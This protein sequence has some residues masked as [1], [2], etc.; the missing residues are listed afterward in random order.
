MFAEIRILDT[1]WET[2]IIDSL[3]ND[4]KTPFINSTSGWA[5][6]F[7]RPNQICYAERF[8][9]ESSTKGAVGYIGESSP[10]AHVYQFHNVY[11]DS[12]NYNEQYFYNLFVKNVSVAA[13]LMLYSKNKCFN[14]EQGKKSIKYVYNLLGDPALNI[15]AS[16]YKITKPTTVPCESVITTKITVSGRGSLIVPDS[17]TLTFY[18]DGDLTVDSG[19]YVVIGDGA[20]INADESAINS[21]I[22]IA[23]D[24]FLFLGRGVTFNDL[25][26]GLNLT[27]EGALFDNGK[28]YDISGVTF[29]NTPLV[30][31]NSHLNVSNCN[32]NNSDLSTTTSISVIDNCDFYESSLLSEQTGF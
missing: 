10:Y 9:R 1:N 27:S 17:C 26:G 11:P 5:G 25:G 7:H 30:H 8:T 21:S 18:R 32:F 2:H 12:L 3:K 6:A 14:W 4:Y 22:N 15:L 20:Q 31:G 16:G 19:G 13:D 24:G 28:T 23:S 29:N